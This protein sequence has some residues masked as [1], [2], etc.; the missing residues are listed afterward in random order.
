MSCIGQMVSILAL[1]TGI[2]GSLVGYLFKLK[3]KFSQILRPK[4]SILLILV[5]S[6]HVTATGPIA[7]WNTSMVTGPIATLIIGS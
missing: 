7:L 3:M 2:P 6:L 1:Q 4:I 5:N